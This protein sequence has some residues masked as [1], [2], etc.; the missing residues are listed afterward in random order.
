MKIYERLLQ[1]PTSFPAP[2]TRVSF[3]VLLSRDF[4]RF[5]QVQC[6]LAGSQKHEFR[7]LGELMNIEVILFSNTMTVQE[8]TS[9]HIS[10]FLR[11]MTDLLADM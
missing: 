7:S 8:A 6:F 4:C 9:P 10:H 5:P 2:C 11:Y 1:A 3:R